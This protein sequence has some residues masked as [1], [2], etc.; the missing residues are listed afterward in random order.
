ME[1]VFGFLWRHHDIGSFLSLEALDRTESRNA[2][3]YLLDAIH[4]LV[5]LSL[6]FLLIEKSLEIDEAFL[7]DNLLGLMRSMVDFLWQR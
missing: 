1:V 6:L 5:K 2:A 4:S 7:L 3:G